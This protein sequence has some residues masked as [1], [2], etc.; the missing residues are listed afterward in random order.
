[1]ENPELTPAQLAHLSPCVLRSVAGGDYAGWAARTV[2]GT[3]RLLDPADPETV[4]YHFLGS[5]I[6]R[7]LD[8]PQG[9]SGAYTVG[10]FAAGSL[11]RCKRHIRS[12]MSNK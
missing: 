8:T 1:M 7:D 9:Y 12:A 6:L 2:S 4:E 10:V 11:A 5:C 3:V